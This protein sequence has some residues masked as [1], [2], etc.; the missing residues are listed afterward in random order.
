MVNIYK[1][2]DSS[3]LGVAGV[4]ALL[5]VTLV[6]DSTASGMAVAGTDLSG[7]YC[8]RLYDLLGGCAIARFAA[9]CC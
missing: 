6:V 3:A 2:G 1:N 9:S 4:S 7:T 8:G 5:G